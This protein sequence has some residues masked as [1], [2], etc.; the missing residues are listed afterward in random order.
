[1]SRHVAL[2]FRIVQRLM[3]GGN[4]GR[5]KFG[6]R[7]KSLHGCVIAH[8][9]IEHMRKESRIGRSTAKRVR[10]DP[11]FGQERTQPLGV[12]GNKRKCL[13]GNDFSHFPGVSRGLSQAG[14]LPF[15]NLWSLFSKRSCPSLRKVFKQLATTSRKVVPGLN[16]LERI[17]R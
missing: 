5:M 13:N 2:P 1:M 3:G 15:R 12:A 16:G 10:P 6:S 4:V 11:A 9:E 14:Y 7:G 8:D 17:W